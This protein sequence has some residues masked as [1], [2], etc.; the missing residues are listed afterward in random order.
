MKRQS[1]ESQ[2][3][4]S[5]GYDPDKEQLEIEFRKNGNVYRYSGFGAVAWKDFTEATSKGRFFL[6]FVKPGNYTYQRIEEP[7]EDAQTQAARS[8]EADAQA[9]GSEATEK[10]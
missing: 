7:S 10:Y 8:A 9:T 4:A 6:Q 5:I 1:V 2:L 3:I